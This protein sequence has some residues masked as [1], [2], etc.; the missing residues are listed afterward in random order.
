MS[1][2]QCLVILNSELQ[3]LGE[4]WFDDDAFSHVMLGDDGEQELG[5][6]IEE[7]QTQGLD[8][9]TDDEEDGLKASRINLRDDDFSDALDDWLQTRGYVSLSLPEQAVPTWHLMQS[10]YE[11]PQERF[12]QVVSLRDQDDEK[13]VDWDKQY[14]I[15]AFRLTPGADEKPVKKTQHA[16][17]DKK[18]KKTTKISG[19]RKKGKKK[20]SKS[21]KSFKSVKSLK[22][23]RGKKQKRKK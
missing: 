18:V 23:Q 3:P 1:D 11:D 8:H 12:D 13:G 7:W 21:L 17:P 10:A 9:V 2:K 19:V 20:S 16:M 6:W 15:L 14:Q 5:P 22:S 4:V